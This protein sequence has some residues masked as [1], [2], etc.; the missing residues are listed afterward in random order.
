MKLLKNVV[1][2]MLVVLFITSCD[3]IG[4]FNPEFLPPD[5]DM[6][7]ESESP[8]YAPETPYA[9]DTPEATESSYAP[10]PAAS[11]S[12]YSF[13][14][15]K[16][17]LLPPLD[18]TLA[19]IDYPKI[20]ATE[21]TLDPGTFADIGAYNSYCYFLGDSMYLYLSVDPGSGNAM[22]IALTLMLANA[23]QA[24][25]DEYTA[26]YAFLAGFIEYDD[27]GA[28]VMNALNITDVTKSMATSANGKYG[29]FWYTND[30][31]RADLIIRKANNT[32]N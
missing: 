32:T 19:L 15:T 27:Y 4:Y 14:F 21:R 31:S 3:E 24:S 2:M 9:T 13:N 8:S 11:A 22:Q 7:T 28:T 18:D 30:G 16:G 10:T 12:V 1:L 5:T 17:D 20:A 26:V 23:T 6:S 29:N 25:K